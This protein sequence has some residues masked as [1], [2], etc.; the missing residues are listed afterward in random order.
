MPYITSEDRDD[1][2]PIEREILARPPQTAG[3]IQ[4]LISVLAAEYLSNT[5]YRYQNM[6]DVM[7]ALAGAQ[8]EFYRRHVGPYEDKCIAKNGDVNS[9]KQLLSETSVGEY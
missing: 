7:G 4:Y 6:N 9:N 8:Q 1:L 3:E 5:E 2:W